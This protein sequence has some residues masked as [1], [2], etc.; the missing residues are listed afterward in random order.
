MSANKKFFIFIV[1]SIT[2]SFLC[3]IFNENEPKVDNTCIW[4]DCN[5]PRKED[6]IYCLGHYVDHSIKTD[7]KVNEK[8][9]QEKAK[10]EKAKEAE[11]KSQN[12]K[13][14]ST[15][16]YSNLPDCDDYDDYEDFMDN[17]DGYMPS[18]YDAEDYW[19]DW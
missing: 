7:Q 14:Y 9:R 12:K 17:W 10:K 5:K 1:A 6:S 11:K 18:G 3:M 8:K 13:S 15:N 16:S 2:I 19:E 4:S